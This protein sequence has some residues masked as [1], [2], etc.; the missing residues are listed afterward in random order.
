MMLMSGFKM[1]IVIFWCK[2]SC[3]TVHRGD[4]LCELLVE[5][6]SIFSVKFS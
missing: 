1:V 4:V 2:L 3:R 6:P 5:P